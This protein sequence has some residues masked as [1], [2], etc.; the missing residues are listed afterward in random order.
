MQEYQS[1]E[2]A[3]KSIIIKNIRKALQERGGVD[4]A[5]LFG[6]FLSQNTFRDIDIAIFLRPEMFREESRFDIET[7]ISDKL[8]EETGLSFELFDIKILNG[9]PESFLSEVFSRGRL[10]FAR[11]R[12]SL[13][14][15]IE[16]VSQ[17]SL[18]NEHIA[19][20]SFRELV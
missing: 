17:F 4:F 3:K 15:T 5:Y 10:L 7:E 14:D 8:Q 2:K 11:D 1:L 13:T 6:S 12:G 9:A 20:A 18:A 16:R 19:E